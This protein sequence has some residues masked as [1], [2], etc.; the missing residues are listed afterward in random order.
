MLI[1]AGGLVQGEEFACHLGDPQDAVPLEV[2]LELGLGA[3]GIV[4]GGL[5]LADGIAQPGV[6]G[7]IDPGA[8]VV[9]VDAAA[10]VAACPSIPQ[11]C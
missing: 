2:A 3:A 5:P 6:V 4:A 1:S 10:A 11:A 8:A 7:Q 9:V